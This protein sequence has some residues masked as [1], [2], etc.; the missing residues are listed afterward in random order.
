MVKK[1]KFLLIERIGWRLASKAFVLTLA[2]GFLARSRYS[3]W[4]VVLFIFLFWNFKKVPTGD[5]GAVGIS[6]YLWPLLALL[7]V[8]IARAAG[9]SALP[10]YLVFFLGF[11]AT[12][13]IGHSLWTHRRRYYNLLNTLLL[14]GCFFVYFQSGASRHGLMPLALLGLL[15]ILWLLFRESL[16]FFGTT[17]SS[18]RNRLAA[19]ILTLIGGEA[20]ILGSF[21]PLVVWGQALVITALMVLLRDLNL[22]HFEGSLTRPVIFNHLRFFILVV[23]IIFAA[24]GPFF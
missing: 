21:L 11:W 9:F 6:L 2:L 12:L 19:A 18:S 5:A 14:F 1:L 15:L 10:V 13:S 4:A 3:F 24:A 20:A 22:F 16:V 7:T 23:L 8:E 17:F